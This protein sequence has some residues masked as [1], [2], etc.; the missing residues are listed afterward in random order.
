MR[1]RLL[2][3]LAVAVFAGCRT[4][5]VHPPSAQ[6]WDMRRPEL[7]ARDRF[8]LK[9]RVAVAASGEGF[10]ARLR[11]AQ[12]GARSQ[13]ALE[14]PLGAG[15]VQVTSDGSNLSIVTSRGE[16]FNDD[17]ARTELA[18]RLG[19]EPPLK[20]LRY[21][22]LGVPDPAQPATEAVDPEQHRL[23]SLQQSG[24][25]IDYGGYMPVGSEWLPA[26]LTLQRAGVRVRL[27]VDGWNS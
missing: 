27:I 26:R 7:Q 10:N 4:V 1:I 12:E 14:G 22:I 19:F 5:P 6:P 16:R 9:G 24:W 2:W 25:H 13:L 18:A 23:Q 20:S 8:E 3:I 15:G 21:W 17:T 11:W